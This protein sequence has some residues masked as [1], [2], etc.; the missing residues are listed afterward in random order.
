MGRGPYV[1]I[2]ATYAKAR[3]AGRIVSIAT[4]IAVGVDTDGRREVLGAATGPSEA[5]TFSHIS[6]LVCESS[7]REGWT[8]PTE[9]FRQDIRA[10]RQL[11]SA[12]LS[13]ICNMLG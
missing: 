3:E 6:I 10:C 4:I 7:T 5:E 1:W 12:L 9:L 2:D 8:L 13:P 11:T